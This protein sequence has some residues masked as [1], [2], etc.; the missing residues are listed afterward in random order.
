[1][2]ERLGQFLRSILAAQDVTPKDR[3]EDSDMSRKADLVEEY[4]ICQNQASRLE[5]NVWQTAT[6][7]GIGSIVGL[8]SLAKQTSSQ[9][10]TGWITVM[11]AS[12]VTINAT[13]VW[14]RF[15]RRW[16]SIQHLKYE[17]M[18]EI[19]TVVGLKQSQMVL[20][21]DSEA[22]QH[23]RYLQQEGRWHQRIL[24]LLCFSLPKDV[25]AAKSERGK[26]QKYEYRGIQPAGRL[27]VF[28]IS[29]PGFPLRF[30]RHTKLKGSCGQ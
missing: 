21:R 16:W 7:L 11:L 14:W 22:Q 23:R 26:M 8:V 9:C 24:S 13:I 20:E 29:F 17:R 15:A 30:A 1:M 4:R 5:T 2:F 10:Q 12:A 19:E 3:E 18:R 6:L 27:L 25:Q 28:T